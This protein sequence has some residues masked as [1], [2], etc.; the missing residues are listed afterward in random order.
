V[1]PGRWCTLYGVVSPRSRYPTKC[2]ARCRVQ[3]AS[4]PTINPVYAEF[5]EHYGIA[6]TPARPH[7]PKDKAMVK[8][9][10]QIVQRWIIA[11]LRN[12]IIFSL[13]DLNV[14]IAELFEDL[15]TRRFKK[16]Q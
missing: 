11:R 1:A 16:R 5:A 14:A 3:I 4:T 12:V 7:K 10:V 2:A 15:N 8:M 9:G 13:E 6:V